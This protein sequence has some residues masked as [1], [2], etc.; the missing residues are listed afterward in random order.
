[1]DLPPPPPLVA[2]SESPTFSWS[3]IIR[4]LEPDRSEVCG[5]GR[6]LILLPLAACEFCRRV[7]CPGEAGV[8]G[9][10]PGV[11]TDME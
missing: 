1:V 2:A 5:D 4:L 6:S 11:T 10:S 3:S 9:S 8:S 7:L